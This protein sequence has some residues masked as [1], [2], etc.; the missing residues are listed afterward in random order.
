MA[1]RWARWYKEQ[2]GKH[3][4]HFF[5][6]GYKRGNVIMLKA[7][8]MTP[9]SHYCKKGHPSG[10]MLP[11]RTSVGIFDGVFD[12]GAYAAVSECQVSISESGSFPP[13]RWTCSSS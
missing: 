5:K 12:E 11:M 1:A 8:G 3:F 4:K 7:E 9:L 13:L 6:R 10:R 2:Y